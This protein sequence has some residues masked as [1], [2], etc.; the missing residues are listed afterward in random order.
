MENGLRNDMPDLSTLK[1]VANQPDFSTLK[2]ITGAFST[3]APQPQSIVD[4]IWGG[5]ANPITG[6]GSTNPVNPISAI[7]DQ[8]KGGLQQTQ[9]GASEIA[10]GTP[11]GAPAGVVPGAIQGLSSGLKTGSGIASMASSFLA[12]FFKPVGDA[13]N[14]TGDLINKIPGVTDYLNKNSDA[15]TKV[16]QPLADAGNIAGTIL[17]LDG[18]AKA[19]PTVFKTTQDIVNPIIQQ[20]QAAHAE[21]TAQTIDSLAGQITQGKTADIPKAKAA[22]SSIDA[23]GVQTYKDLY[24]ALNDKV[25]AIST[26]LDQTLDTNTEA[27]PLSDLNVTAKVGDSTVSHNY[28]EDA[29]SQLKQHY[30][31]T[32]DIPALTAIQQLEAKANATGLTAKEVNNLARE[33]GQAIN[34]FN[35]NGQAAAGLS[36]QAA[37]NTRTGLK[38]T[39]R[40]M[41]DNPVFKAAD[42]SMANLIRTRDLVGDVAE[43]VNQL[44]QKIQT[45]SWGE[46]AGRLAGEVINLVGLNSPKGLVEYFLS[47]GTG[48]KTLNALD[49]ESKLSGNLKSLQAALSPDA[50]Q[51]TIEARLQEIISEFQSTNGKSTPNTK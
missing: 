8:F 1:P 6:Q 28:V 19:A 40:E 20:R 43:K 46:R 38:S 45:R 9:Q 48:L 36:K 27:K 17:G 12:P 5:M 15:I 50:P 35:A 23:T 32:N 21:A 49:L 26:K 31:T 44:Q 22:L 39:A 25:N 33:H 11:N 3:P 34:A 16:T 37:E 24:T 14:A 10:A 41:F 42:S 51:A 47:R 18:V 2:P 30:T 7:T 13:I 4:K 29:I